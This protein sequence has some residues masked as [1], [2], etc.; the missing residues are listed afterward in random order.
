[1]IITRNKDGPK[2]TNYELDPLLIIAAVILVMV[3]IVGGFMAYH[4]YTVIRPQAVAQ[5]DYIQSLSCDQILSFP[6]TTPLYSKDNRQL[7]TEKTEKCTEARQLEA[8][9]EKERLDA[10]LADPNSF[11]SLSREYERLTESL[12]EAKVRY[13]N[14]TNQ[15]LALQ[16]QITEYENRISEIETL[17]PVPEE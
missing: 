2:F 7:L 15:T 16:E 3:A 13:E 12:A 1:M 8:Q 4:E 14:L 17:I 10:L 6:T 5:H 11:E 9:K